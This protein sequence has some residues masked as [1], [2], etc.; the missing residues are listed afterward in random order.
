MWVNIPDPPNNN[1]PPQM[2]QYY[3]MGYPMQVPPVPPKKSK[4][5]K[6][7]EEGPMTKFLRDLKEQEEITKNLLEYFKSKE[8]S[9]KPKD[10]KKKDDD[11]KFSAV[12]MATILTLVT[13]AAFPMSIWGLGIALESLKHAFK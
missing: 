10:D 4:G 5:R 3:P 12:Q 13:L 1:T 2:P 9:K 7:R 6:A 11:I 8:D